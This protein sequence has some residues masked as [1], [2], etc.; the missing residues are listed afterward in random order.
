MNIIWITNIYKII[1][2]CNLNILILKIK[3]YNIYHYNL[4][5]NQEY[6]TNN[7]IYI[8]I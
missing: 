2:M 6:G 7:N 1:I 3:N 5:I 4:M 8:I